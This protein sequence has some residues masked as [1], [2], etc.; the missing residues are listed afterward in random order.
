MIQQLLTTPRPGGLPA[1]LAGGQ[2]QGR[3]GIAGIATKYEGTGIK[4]YKE[5]DK[6]QEWEFI[7]DPK[8]DKS[9]A[10]GQAAAQGNQN[11]LGG[12][13]SRRS[14]PIGQPPGPINPGFG[15]GSGGFGQP[16]RRQ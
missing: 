15:P 7:Y 3:G 5:R 1:G 13:D 10:G 11:P 9:G 16:G 14:P 8:E 2:P 4:V 6:Y 12:S